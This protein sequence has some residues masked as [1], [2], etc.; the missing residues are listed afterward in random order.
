MLISPE[1]AEMNKQLHET[2]AHYGQSSDKWVQK[3]VEMSLQYECADILDYGCGKGLLKQGIGSKVKEY[4]P[5]LGKLDKEPADMV[6]CTDVMEHIEPDCLDDVL[7]DLMSLT[8]K[9]A[10]ITVSTRLARKTLADGRNAHLIV[11]PA[12]WW[13]PK[14]MS[15]F[16]LKQ[17]TD[18]G[19]EFVLLLEKK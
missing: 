11:Q 9:V 6:V 3:V 15:R 10:F 14:F 17:F 19:G 18:K 1:Y 16:H 5:A 13:L 8:K 7:D 4:D 12:E 2:N